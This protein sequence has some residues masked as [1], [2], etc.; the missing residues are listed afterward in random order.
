LALLS[1]NSWQFAALNFATARLGV[2]LAPVN[3]ML[4]GHEIAFILDHSGAK[5]FVVE[6]ALV[7]TAEEALAGASSGTVVISRRRSAPPSPPNGRTSPRGS[8]TK[9]PHLPC[10]SPTTTRC[11]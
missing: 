4:T 7:P 10:T 2:V 11:G 9:A 5:V 3:F 8:S 6:D 1:H